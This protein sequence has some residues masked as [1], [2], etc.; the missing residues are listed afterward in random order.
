M[1]VEPV[2]QVNLVVNAPAPELDARH[3]EVGEQRHADGE[4]GRGLLRREATCGRKRQA[5]GLGVRWP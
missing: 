3:M 2:I 5:R 4:I 1:L